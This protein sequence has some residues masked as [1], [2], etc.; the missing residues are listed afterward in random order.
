[1]ITYVFLDFRVNIYDRKV[2]I[3]EVTLAFLMLL[4]IFLYSYISKCR[5]SV[6]VVLEWLLILF[7][8][9]ILLTIYLGGLK[10]ASE[11]LEL[12]ILLSRVTFVVLRSIVII[13]KLLKRKH[14]D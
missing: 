2:F 12:M 11:E 9:A 8:S 4:D 13:Y 7:Y 3:I 6:S 1:M 10:E 5:I 14:R